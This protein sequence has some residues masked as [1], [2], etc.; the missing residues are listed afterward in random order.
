MQPSGFAQCEPPH[1]RL[2]PVVD[3]RRVER[4]PE[5]ARQPHRARP[6]AHYAE[7][8]EQQG[9]KDV[10]GVGAGRDRSRPI[11]PASASRPSTVN[12][13]RPS[14]MTTKG[15][16]STTSVHPAG[17]ENSSPFASCR[18]TRSSPQFCRCTTNSKSWPN[19]GWNRCVTRTRRYRSS[20]QRASLTLWSNAIAERWIGG[21][22]RELLDRTLI[23]NQAQPAPDPAPVR[24]SPQPAPAAP[25]PAR[26]RAAETATRTGR[27]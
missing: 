27:S 24:N 19:S 12:G 23:W 10:C 2:S 9:H 17:S 8:C 3:C 18:W 7:E 1:R 25:L 15:S 22:R 26:S 20:E 13:Q 4:H 11:R 6:D 14:A 5:N 16:A 21:C